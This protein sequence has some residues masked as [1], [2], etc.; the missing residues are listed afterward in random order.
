M[1]D[2]KELLNVANAYLTSY[3]RRSE[4]QRLVTRTGLCNAVGG[5]IPEIKDTGKYWIDT[6]QRWNKNGEL[7]DNPN[8]KELNDI[9]RAMFCL[10]LAQLTDK[11]YK[12]IL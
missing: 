9:I 2:N 8:F 6:R 12:E 3:K 5:L 4:W 10:F 11:E 7:I 1:K